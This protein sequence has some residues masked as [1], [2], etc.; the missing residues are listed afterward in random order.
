MGCYLS[1]VYSL[2]TSINIMTVYYIPQHVYIYHSMYIYTTACIYI[3]HSMYIYTTACIYIPQHVYIY[4]TACIY[5]PQHVY[6]YHSMYIYTIYILEQTLER[7][8]QNKMCMA[9]M[10]ASEMQQQTLERQ[11]QN[12]IRMASMRAGA[13][14]GLSVGGAKYA[15]CYVLRPLLTSFPHTTCYTKKK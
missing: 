9:S 11:E 8:E 13:D 1:K 5:I 3:Y 12:K 4:T 15:K 7:Q 14:P 6:I 10:G 2:C